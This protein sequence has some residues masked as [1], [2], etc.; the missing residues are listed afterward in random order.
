MFEER[1]REIFVNRQSK[2]YIELAAKRHF[3]MNLYQ[4]LGK[5]NYDDYIWAE[6][7]LAKIE[8]KDYLSDQDLKDLLKASDIAQKLHLKS[9]DD[10]EEQE[11]ATEYYIWHTQG[12]DK[13]RE[14][15][16]ALSGRIFAWAD[17]GLQPGDDYNC[18]CWAEDYTPD[19]EEMEKINNGEYMT[20]EEVLQK[21]EEEREREKEKEKEVSNNSQQKPSNEEVANR[22]RTDN[23]DPNSP[24]SPKE[25]A[26]SSKGV[27]FII[28]EEGYQETPYRVR[29]N[30]GNP[31]GNPTIGYGHDIRGNADIPDKI[32]AQQAE[33]ILDNDLKE[34]EKAVRNRVKVPLT[35]YQF[36]ALVSYTYNVGSGNLRDS[37]VLKYVNEGNHEAAAEALKAPRYSKD[38][39]DN[40]EIKPGSVTRGKKESIL[41]SDGIY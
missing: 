10:E 19:E 39:D 11:H 28:G 21:V 38:G 41:Y 40:Y 6:Q 24:K 36:D 34:A 17:G 23:P 12:D 29:D 9:N 35:Q 25:M 22:I 37:D 26:A 5:K 3:Y 30:Q 15:H 7:F 18:R 16:A 1:S 32:T 27:L 31:S 33:K 20:V 2:E 8:K 14:G 13:V 4:K